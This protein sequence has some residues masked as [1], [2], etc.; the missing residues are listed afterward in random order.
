METKVNNDNQK[1]VNLYLEAN[2]N[3]NSMK[4]VANYM[5]VPEGT[6]YDFPDVESTENAPLAKELFGF[7]YVD[8][9]FYMSNFITIT[10]KEQYEWIEIKDALKQHIKDYIES[11][12][13][14]ITKLMPEE[15]Y[16]ES[17][18]ETV[19][20]IKG[21]LDEY[22]KP[23]VEQDG[24]AISFHAYEDGIVKVLLQGSC[25]GCP[26]STVTLKAGIENLLKRMLPEIKGVEAEGI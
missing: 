19:K 4:F 15:Q 13:E 17:D 26:S 9:V 25:S 7:E 22:I 16:D 23:A 1:V 12:K 5:L 20:K 14:V 11:G 6:S 10:K 18:S 8:R 21:I 3:P 24:G 2:P